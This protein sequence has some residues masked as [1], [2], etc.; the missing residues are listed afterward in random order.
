MEKLWQGYIHCVEGCILWFVHLTQTLST[1]DLQKI[2]SHVKVDVQS[3]DRSSLVRSS[4]NSNQMPVWWQVTWSKKPS[5]V[6]NQVKVESQA[7]WHIKWSSN[8]S[9]WVMRK[10]EW[11]VMLSDKSSWV[12]QDKKVEWQV[13]LSGKSNQVIRQVEWLDKLGDKT[14]WVTRKVK[15]QVKYKSSQVTSSDK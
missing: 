13:N 5:Q 3:N 1:E 15:W 9:S 2:Y 12:N 14:S 8:K 11:K 6:T 7:K 10:V 4:E